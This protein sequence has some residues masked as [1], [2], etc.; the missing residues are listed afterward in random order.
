[1]AQNMLLCLKAQKEKKSIQQGSI[2]TFKSRDF[3]Q[4]YPFLSKIHTAA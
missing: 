1:M 4:N 2:T 3:Q